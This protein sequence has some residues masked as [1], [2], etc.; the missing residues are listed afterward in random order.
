ML[1]VIRT[2]EKIK[3]RYK[4]IYFTTIS[5]PVKV[6]ISYKLQCNKIL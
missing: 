5:P 4:L 3:F 6:V 2:I 1:N